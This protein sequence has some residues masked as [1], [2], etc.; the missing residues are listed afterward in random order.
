MEK[1]KPHHDLEKFKRSS[2]VITS[3]ALKDAFSLGYNRREL[4]KI[5]KRME[6]HDFYKSMTSMHNNSCWQ[7]VYHV[8]DKEKGLILY[9]KFT[10]D[11]ICE[12]KL[13]SFKEK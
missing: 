11:I 7:D 5:I 13:L 1:Q 2:Y 9:V 4:R 8:P 6:Q 12:F 10:D 3:T